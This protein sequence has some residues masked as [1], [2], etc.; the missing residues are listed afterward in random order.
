MK[1]DLR[2]DR[3]ILGSAKFIA[4]TAAPE[5]EMSEDELL[6]ETMRRRHA[7]QSTS[8]KKQGSAAKEQS[9]LDEEKTDTPTKDTRKSKKSG[10]HGLR[11][12]LI[13][14]LLLSVIAKYMQHTGRLLPIYFDARSYILDIIDPQDEVMEV[15]EYPEL[16]ADTV[17]S[18]DIFNR[19]MPMTDDIAALADSLATVP[20]E[21]LMADT[22]Y[23]E[24]MDS[25]DILAQDSGYTVIPEEVLELSD[26]DITIINNRSLLLM[27]TELVESYPHRSGRGKMF[28]KRDGVT[29]SAPRGGEWVSEMKN[30]LDRFV[31]GNFNEDYN[32]GAAEISSKFEIIMNA[33]QD[34]QPQVLDEMR[35]L[36]VLAQPFN[37]YLKQ[38][39]IDL[40]KGINNNPAKFIFEGSIQE[41]QYILSAWAETRSNFILR[42]VEIDFNS[43]QM[44]LTFNVTFFQYYE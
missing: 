31:L 20:P 39:I 25:S 29:I 43:G 23:S 15:Q 18:D 24:P 34:F 36:D 16:P 11:Y 37:D 3:G 13:F 28:L 12:F 26:D 42:S 41:I 17:L 32:S 1:I 27:I 8:R 35:L 38:I 10:G 4:N 6:V 22:M 2:K 14:I 7:N 9:E 33:E 21:S 5:P 40:P 30:T 19:L 44:T